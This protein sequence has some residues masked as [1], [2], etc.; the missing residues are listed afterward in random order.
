MWEPPI[1]LDVGGLPGRR[2]AE[3]D[4]QAE[5]PGDPGCW[6]DQQRG[7]HLF[8]ALRVRRRAD[9]EPASAELPDLGQE[10][11]ELDEMRVTRLTTNAR[12]ERSARGCDCLFRFTGR[13]LE[14]MAGSAQDLGR[15]S[16][17][18]FRPAW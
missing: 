11:N 16:G 10:G 12:L 15:Y 6:I 18:D 5:R 8:C 3:R 4:A 7:A 2:S 13:L 9:G 17:S 1:R 14:A